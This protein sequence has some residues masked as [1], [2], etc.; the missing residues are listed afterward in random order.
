MNARLGL[1]AA[2][3]CSVLACHTNRARAADGAEGLPLKLDLRLGEANAK[4]TEG[5]PVYGRGD[6]LYG[7]TDRESTLEGDA[8]LRRSGTVIRGDRVT[9]YPVDDEEIRKSVG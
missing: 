5:R 1:L 7:R 9:Y 3:A 8:E 6:R 2:L 4:V